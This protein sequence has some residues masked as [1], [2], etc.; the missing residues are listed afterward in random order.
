MTTPTK[1]QT[2]AKSTSAKSTPASAK[3]TAPTPAP[4]APAKLTRADVNA[5]LTE[6]G[7][8]GPRSY[9]MTDLTAVLEWVVAGAPQDA[10]AG[11]PNGAVQHLYPAAKPERVARKSRAYLAAM[12]EVRDLLASGTTLKALTAHVDAV[13]AANPTEEEPTA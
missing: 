7:Y 9:T 11:V 12:T 4:E 13:L 10:A 8:A 3:K 5:K 6:L 1:T 2:A